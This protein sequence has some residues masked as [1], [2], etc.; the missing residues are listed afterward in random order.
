M[1]R[2]IALIAL[3]ALAGGGVGAAYQAVA[4]QRHYRDLMVRGDAALRDDQTYAAIE[5]YSGAIALRDDSMLPY[6]RRGQTYQRQ[7][8]LE[9]AAKD[10]R[11]AAARDATA[12]RPLED[13][14]DVLYQDQHY[15]GSVDAYES[16]L[17]LDD[18]STRL[19]FKLALAQYRNRDLT[20]TM[21]TLDRVLRMDAQLPDALY[22]RGICL[23]ETNRPADAVRALE[24]AVAISPGMIPA[25]EELADLYAAA[26]RRDAELEQLQALALLDKDHVDRQVAVGL[27][28]AGAGR[29]D[30]AVLTLGRALEQH[31]DADVIYRAIG[32]VWLDRPRDDRTFL[33]KAREA[34]ERVASN[35]GATSEVLTLY[36]KALLQD[37]DVGRAEQTLHEATTRT[38]VE[39]SAFLLYATAAEKQNHFSAARTA[40]IQ[41]GG[42]APDTSDFAARAARIAQ[43]SL[44][45]NETGAAVDWLRKATLASPA[46]NRM[47]AALA[48]AQLRAGD[49]VAARVTVAR[50]L[51]REPKNASLLALAR[52]AR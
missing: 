52:R 8:N 33:S 26:G 9:E 32:Q 50:G 20:A 36:G 17:R 27:A 19:H 37:G 12:P 23:R 24:Q 28:H 39:P 47:L 41:Y 22:L 45:M 49:R 5:A 7:G 4:H 34:L 51:E 46:D 29:W 15:P 43:L 13:L 42:L 30:L 38:P 21:A 1:R 25:R 16:S 2:A 18:H 31:P 14:G 6:L 10:F 40:L 35:T 11:Y 3:L 48:D 44:K